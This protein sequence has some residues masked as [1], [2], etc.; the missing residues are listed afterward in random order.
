M[1][2][3]LPGERDTRWQRLASASSNLD[4]DARWVEL[5]ATG[6]VLRVEG[7]GLVESDDLSTEDVLSCGQVRG[8]GDVIL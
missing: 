5:S 7:V 3:I 8:N 1:A 2:W 4:L 6:R